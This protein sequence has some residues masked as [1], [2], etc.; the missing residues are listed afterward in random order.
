MAVEMVIVTT[1]FGYIRRFAP[2][3]NESDLENW[4]SYC[5]RLEVYNYSVLRIQEKMRFQ[6]LSTK[7]ILI[8]KDYV[9]PVLKSKY[10]N[11][12]PI[13]L[14]STYLRKSRYKNVA[15]SKY[16]N[17]QAINTVRI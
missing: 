10:Q 6:S 11:L 15:W 2:N 9:F 1:I 14:L 13:K 5:R 7:T 17:I 8:I 12:F 4:V 16:S 3:V